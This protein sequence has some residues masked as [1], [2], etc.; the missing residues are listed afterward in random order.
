MSPFYRGRVRRVRVPVLQALLHSLPGQPAAAVEAGPLAEGR[1]LDPDRPGGQGLGP[2]PELPAHRLEEKVGGLEQPAAEDDD[3]GVEEADDVGDAHAEVGHGVGDDLPGQGIAA[4]GRLG[5]GLRGHGLGPAAGQL[6]HDRRPALSQSFA[7]FAGHGIAR[8]LRL[9][10]AHRRVGGLEV[11]SEAEP[12]DGAG[13]VLVAVDD[14]AAG[15][16]PGPDAGADGEEHGVAGAR[17]GAFPGFAG[18]IGAA[19]GLEDQGDRRGTESPDPLQ[20]RVLVPAWDVGRPDLARRRIGDAGNAESDGLKGPAGRRG[21]LGEGAD[22]GPNLGRGRVAAVFIDG[23]LRRRGKLAVAREQGRGDLGPA[24]IDGAAE[25]GHRPVT[26]TTQASDG[27]SVF[28]TTVRSP[29][30]TTPTAWPVSRSTAA[31][32]PAWVLTPNLAVTGLSPRLKP[33][34]SAYPSP[35]SRRASTSASGTPALTRT[36][37]AI[38]SQSASPAKNLPLLGFLK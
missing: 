5:H 21:G 8:G 2:A 30:R 19:V 38:L 26:L 3:F 18:D 20:Q 23:R 28:S 14:A 27:W 34:R 25:S 29:S 15:D 36:A 9:E 24:D 10:A 22:R 33:K 32:E 13:D 35:W 7:G 31:V 4:A 17:G 16:D 11:R 6:E 1:D 37:G 12:A